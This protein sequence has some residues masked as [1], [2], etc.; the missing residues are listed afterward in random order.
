MTGRERVIQAIDHREP[1][2]IPVDCGGMRSTGILGVAYDKLKTHLGI[3]GGEIKMYDVPQQLCVPEQWYL[4]M[5]QIDVVD[6]ARRFADNRDDWKDWDLPDGT[7]ARLPAWLDI[8][9][10]GESWIAKNGEGEVS[11][12]MP[13]S[14]FYFD[15]KIWPMLGSDMNSFDDLGRQMG[16]TMWGSLS[17]PL[18]KNAVRPDF[19]ELLREEAKKLNDTTGY[20]SMIGFGANLF[21]WGQF[22]YGTE[23]FLVNILAYPK[24]MGKM[25]DKLTEIHMQN[26]E[27]LLEAISPYITVIQMGDD[28]GTQSAPMLSPDLYHKMF[29]PRHKK[30]YQMVRDAGGPALFLHSCGAISEFLPDLIDAGVQII[31]PVQIAAS[32]MEPAGL[33]QE[34]GRDLVFWGGGVD[35]QHVL[36]KA[37][38]DE[39]RREV[40]KNAEVLMKDGGFVFTQVHN[41]QAGVPPENVL[42]M[43]DEI[44]KI[45]Y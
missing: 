32:G 37:T 13:G 29:Y 5:F 8:T 45:R 23:E 44:N 34:Y 25:L 38:P 39:V 1:D 6:I 12:V 43:Y 2:K 18:W 9:R 11:G 7:P 42:A 36:P 27:P 19:Y 15:Q 28:L 16:R 10:D 4:D 14:S 17:D 26:L 21:E 40:R 30:I 20:A 33:K 3:E 41:I 24:E 35:T 22:L 31:N